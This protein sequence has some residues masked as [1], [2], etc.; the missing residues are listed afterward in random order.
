V[1]VKFVTITPEAEKTIAYIARVS[2]PSNQ[3]NSDYAKL[4]RYCINH[5]HWSIFEQSYMTVEIETSVAIATQLLRH[6][7]FT[8]QQFSQRYAD[9][10]ELGFEQVQWR[11]Q[12]EKNRQSSG[13]SIDPSLFADYSDEWSNILELIQ[14]L[15]QSMLSFG[16][17]KECARFILPQCT[18]TRIYM[19]GNIRSW[20]HYLQ[21]RTQEDTQLEHRQVA[22]EIQKIFVE[23]LPV[24]AAALEWD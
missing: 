16:V 14:D 24:T 2:N 12:A 4:L 21:L 9:V 1:N 6:R 7:S 11:K 3:N 13:E 8:F 15:Y 22:L 19:S 10:S 17:A 23:N 18:S 5:Q 20:I